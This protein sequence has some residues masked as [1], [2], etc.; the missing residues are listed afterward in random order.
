[1]FLPTTQVVGTQPRRYS[2][3]SR[4]HST[5]IREAQQWAV[6]HAGEHQRIGWAQPNTLTSQEAR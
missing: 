1:M 4:Q 3:C 5:H 6:A 2:S